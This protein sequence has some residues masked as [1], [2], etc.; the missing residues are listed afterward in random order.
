ML[1]A[2]F[3]YEMVFGFKPILDNSRSPQRLTLTNPR[4]I[5][6]YNKV[7]RQ[8]HTRLHMRARAFAIQADIPHG[9]TLAHGQEYEKLAYLDECA[10]QHANKKC[11]KL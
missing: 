5:K 7:L 6:R 11:R 4:V 8:E 1:W 2:D 9:L 10:H 3:S